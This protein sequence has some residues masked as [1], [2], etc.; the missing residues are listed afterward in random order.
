[1]PK[2]TVQLVTWNGAKYIPYLFDSLRKQIST[3]W[4]LVILDNGSEDDTAAL[5]QKEIAVGLPVSHTYIKK[6]ANIGFAGGHNELFQTYT[7]SEY[8]LLLNQDMYLEPG[9]IHDLI[10]Y[11]D[12]HE[13]VAAVSPRLMRWDFASLHG[14][15][16]NLNDSFTDYVDALG[17]KVFRSRRVVEW[18][19]AQR[20]RDIKDEYGS[21]TLDVFGVS[22]A[23]P[24]FRRSALETVS[25]ADGTFFDESYGSYKEDVDLAYRLRSAGYSSVVLLGT[26]AYHDRSAAGPKQLTDKAAVRNKKKQSEWIKYHSYKNHIATLIKNEYPRNFLRDLLPIVWYEFK[27][28]M[29]YLLFD[30]KIVAGIKDIDWKQVFKRRRQITRKRT[31]SAQALRIWWT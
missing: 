21:E 11:M 13:H 3:D 20:W 22:G 14:R 31:V 26:V 30:R 6:E 1:M 2:L 25:F 16:S 7:E 17:L 9:C 4:D 19:T 24:C 12:E 15:T 10:V 28:F 8:V 29:W 18:M 23:L 5:V 27:K